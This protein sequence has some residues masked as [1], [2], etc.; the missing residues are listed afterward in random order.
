MEKQIERRCPLSK[1]RM[2]FLVLNYF[3]GYNFVYPL[4]LRQLTLWLNPTARMIPDWM[5]Y[6]V[7]IYMMLVSI[8]VA[9]PILQESWQSL[10]QRKRPVMKSVVLF[11]IAYYFAS[12][13]LN[14]LI[15]QFTDA[16][17]SANQ[18]EIIRAVE[19]SPWLTMLTTMIYAPI[20]E[21]ILFRGVC[22]RALRPH[23][24]AYKAGFI[25]AF[26]FGFIHV[27]T[28][29]FS[30]NFADIIFLFS[31]ALIGFFLV[32]AYEKNDT[33]FASIF[34]HFLNNTIAFLFLL[35]S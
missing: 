14:L 28:S 1:G 18:T 22:Y 5:Q 2:I 17:T 25:S 9:Y 26:A 15:M 8:V 13:L 12:I 33:I 11:M 3:L 29:L 31:Y 20:V 24:N 27:M 34:L 35:V 7:Y 23:M 30:G 21:E 6:F 19:I 16:A 10:R 32:A 4:L